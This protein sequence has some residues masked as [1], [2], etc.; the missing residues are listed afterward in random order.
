MV[1]AAAPRLLLMD[2]PTAGMTHGETLRTAELI[3]RVRP[4]RTLVIVD[5]DMQFVRMIAETVTVFHQGRIV[6]WAAMFGHMTDVGGKVQ[7]S[8]PTDAT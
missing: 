6:G 1:L 8:L 3:E 7:G 5:H 4:G 2:E